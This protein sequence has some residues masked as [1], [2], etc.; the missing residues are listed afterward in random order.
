MCVIDNGLTSVTKI[1]VNCRWSPELTGISS[2]GQPMVATEPR[3]TLPRQARMSA[4][5]TPVT[6]IHTIEVV[7]PWC[8]YRHCFMVLMSTSSSVCFISCSIVLLSSWIFCNEL[9]IYSTIWDYLFQFFSSLIHNLTQTT[10]TD[11][12][13]YYILYDGISRLSSCLVSNGVFFTR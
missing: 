11:R 1:Q 8:V 6:Y 5:A 7:I 12:A 3:V 10:F 4:S 2:G 13:P 9:V